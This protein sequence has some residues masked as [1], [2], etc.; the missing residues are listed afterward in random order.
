MEKIAFRAFGIQVRPSPTTNDHEVRLLGDGQELIDRFWDGAIG[1]DPDDILRTPSPIAPSPIPRQTT[2][3]RCDCGVLGCGDERVTICADGD[4]VLWVDADRTLVFPAAQYTAELRRALDD[5][6]WETPDR[7]AARLLGERVDG[8]VLA[9]SGLSFSWASSRV[10]PRMLTV[11]LDLR[12][13]PYQV[14]VSL[15]WSSESPREI[16]DTTIALLRRDPRS[17]DDVTY[18]PQ[19][20][21]LG[22]PVLDGPGWTRGAG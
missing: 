20:A 6:S 3:A 2:I 8:P 9:R 15:P 19:A 13:G 18:F 21:G 5:S 11:C 16:A 14:L 22:P 7:T 10:R 17:W 1:L 4:E 12:P